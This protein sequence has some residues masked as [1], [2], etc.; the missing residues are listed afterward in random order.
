M[1]NKD[2]FL[3]FLSLI[4][5]PFG[6]LAA[7][8]IGNMEVFP[9]NQEIQ[10]N[11]K[12]TGRVIDAGGEAIIGAS[13][14]EKGT[15]NGTI[16][17]FDGN[18]TLNVRTNAKLVVSYVGYVTQEVM[19]TPNKELNIVLKEDAETLDEVVVVG[20]GSVKKSDLTGA[21]AS[22]STKDLIRSGNTDAV[23]ALQGAMSGVQISRSSSKPGSE[24]NILIRGLNTISGS[25]SPLVVIDGVQGASLSNVN[26]DDIERIDILKDASSTAIYGSRASNGVVLVTTKRGKKGTA[27]I[28]YS[29]YV[30]FRKYTNLPD[31]MSGDEYVQLA[32]ES[33]RASNNNVYKS[34]SEIF[35]SSELKAIENNN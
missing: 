4:C 25:T 8:Q 10:Q 29:G 34:D 32:R 17:D 33:V 14:V 22:V 16:T 31:M 9:I 12:I 2:K 5:L 26:P 24:Y 27:K 23:G 13:I 15:T 19:V 1:N 18:F 20:Y 21:V 7:E 30:G 6:E 28:N 3:M 11:V 35:T